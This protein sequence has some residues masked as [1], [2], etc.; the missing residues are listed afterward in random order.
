[1]KAAEERADEYMR[2]FR[3]SGDGEEP[4]KNDHGF[5]DFGDG[6]WVGLYSLDEMSEAACI[7]RILDG[8][9]ILT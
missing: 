9:R 7:E 2:E 5:Y 4:E 8:V 3:C 1:M 6:I